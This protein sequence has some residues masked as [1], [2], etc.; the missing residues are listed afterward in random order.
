MRKIFDFIVPHAG[1]EFN[2][3]PLAHFGRDLLLGFI[4]W[5]IGYRDFQAAFAV[6]LASGLFEAGNGIAF[7]ADGNHGFFDFLDFLPSPLAGFL[8]IGYLSHDFDL[9]LLLELLAL[10][11]VTVIVLTVLNKLLGRKIVIGK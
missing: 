8:V 11:A 10:Y 1:I 2:L 9:M 4:L 6:M 5:Q 7:N 3:S